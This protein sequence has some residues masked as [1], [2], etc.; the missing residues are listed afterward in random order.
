ME[1][2]GSQRIA[3]EL[4]LRIRSGVLRPGD[5]LPSEGDLMAQ[6]GI[7]KATTSRAMG[8]LRGEGLIIS[9]QGKGTFVRGFRRYDREGTR[10]RLSSPAPAEAPPVQVLDLL[11]AEEVAA[12][13]DV[14]GHLEADPGTLL[15]HRSYLVSLDG[16]PA[17]VVDVYS[18]ADANSAPGEASTRAREFLVGRMPTPDEVELLDLL[19]GTS[20]IEV[21][22]VV[23]AGRRPVELMIWLFD[24]AR[25]R[26]VYDISPACNDAK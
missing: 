10:T 13:S 18:F 2:V 14:A 19:P 8:I 9:H 20:V 21:T 26:F 11:L 6:Y 23:Y 12:S 5:L 16:E 17:Q 3:D 7:S 24:A 25:H 1:S 22:R 4:R 15:I